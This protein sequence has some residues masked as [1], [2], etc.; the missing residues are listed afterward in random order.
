MTGTLLL[1]FLIAAVFGYAVVVGLAFVG[2]ERLVY[3]PQ[4]GREIRLTPQ[5]YGLTHE[6]LRIPTEDHEQLRGG[7][8][9]TPHAARCCCF[10]AM[11]AI[12]DASRLS[13]DVQPHAVLDLIID[14]RGYGQKCGCALGS[15]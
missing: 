13:L 15:E 10:M 12:F 8:A 1:N 6:S 14:Y 9:A 5:A 3:F 11:P 7:C 2:Q 4:V